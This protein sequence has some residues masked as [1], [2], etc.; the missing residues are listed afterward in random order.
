VETLLLETFWERPDSTYQYSWTFS[1]TSLQSDP[2]DTVYQFHA[3]DVLHI[4]T[5]K[6]FRKRDIFEFTP[7]IPEI[8]EELIKNQLDDIQVVPNPYVVANNMEAPLPPAITSGRGERRIEFRKLPSDAT[9]HI[10]T[11]NGTL[12]RIL[13]PSDNMHNGTLAWNLKTRENLDI[14]FGIYFYVIES[15]VGKKSGKLAIIK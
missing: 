6:P 4:E 14:A 10:F 12:V 7:E 1:F 13:K 3:G 15:K 9:V 11:S 2:E 5:T 8:D